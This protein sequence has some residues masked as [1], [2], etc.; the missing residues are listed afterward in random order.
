M[1]QTTTDGLRTLLSAPPDAGN[2]PCLLV[3]NMKTFQHFNI[4]CLERGVQIST[5][6]SCMHAC[7]V[8]V[9]NLTGAAVWVWRDVKRRGR[10]RKRDDRMSWFSPGG[11]AGHFFLRLTRVL[12]QGDGMPVRT[13]VH[14]RFDVSMVL[15]LVA[16]DPATAAR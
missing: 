2:C 9:K 14:S 1:E 11:L 16:T 6:S 4:S 3:Q 12:Q 13:H 7:C 5:E 10:V 8:E 15:K